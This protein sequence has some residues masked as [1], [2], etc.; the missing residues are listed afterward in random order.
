MGIMPMMNAFRRLGLRGG[1]RLRNC[2]RV[3]N[4]KRILNYEKTRC[5]VIIFFRDQEG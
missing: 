2:M 5:Q 1:N 4:A 3:G